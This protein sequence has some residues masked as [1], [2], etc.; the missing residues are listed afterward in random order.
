[1][2]HSQDGLVI[3]LPVLIHVLLLVNTSHSCPESIV[4]HKHHHRGLVYEQ[5]QPLQAELVR[6]VVHVHHLVLMHLLLLASQWGMLL[7]LRI[8]QQAL[9]H[10]FWIHERAQVEGSRLQT[11]SNLVKCLAP[12]EGQEELGDVMYVRVISQPLL[13]HLI[14][15]G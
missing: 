3:G 7:R 14:L 4:D 8:L 1:M 10:V 2:N 11:H 12:K 6:E 9:N 13:L 15:G 5:L